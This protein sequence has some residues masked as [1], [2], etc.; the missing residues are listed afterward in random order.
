MIGRVKQ[1]GKTSAHTRAGAR[2][3]H[4]RL[5]AGDQMRVAPKGKGRSRSAKRQRSA[6]DEGQ[7]KRINNL[8]LVYR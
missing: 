8:E 1:G 4:Y 3:T 7:R 6:M 5:G 2:I